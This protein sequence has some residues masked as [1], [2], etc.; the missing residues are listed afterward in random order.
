VQTTSPTLSL[1]PASPSHF[2]FF[3]SDPIHHDTPAGSYDA[4]AV[5][6]EL[7]ALIK[8][9]PVIMFAWSFSPFSKNVS[10]WV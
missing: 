8:K 5:Q 9:H 2:L 4:D 1:H 3:I 7:G 6:A 10:R